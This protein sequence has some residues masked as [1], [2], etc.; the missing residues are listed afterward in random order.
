MSV[1][2]CVL[3]SKNTEREMGGKGRAGGRGMGTRKGREEGR[4][5]FLSVLLSI[6]SFLCFVNAYRK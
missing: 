5:K 4:P 3:Y 2:K 6:K 1:V